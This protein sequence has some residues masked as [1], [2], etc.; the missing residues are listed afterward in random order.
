MTGSSHSVEITDLLAH[1]D[2]VGQLARRLVSSPA[3]AEDV[4][5]ETWVAAL[6]RPPA[7][8]DNPRG[9]LG[10]VARNV[11]RQ[12]ARGEKRRSRRELAVDRAGTSASVEELATRASLQRDVVGH[13]LALDE[14]LRATILLRF[15]EGLPPREVAERLGISPKT[16]SHRTHRALEM[17]RERLDGEFGAR[18]TWCAALAPLCALRGSAEVTAGSSVA[19]IGGWIV[20]TNAKMGLGVAVGLLGSLGLWRVLD[21]DR[22]GESDPQ[23][24]EPV[25]LAEGP[26][27]LPPPP[28]EDARRPVADPEEAEEEVPRV[29]LTE[30]EQATATSS[31]STVRGRVVDVRG[32]GLESVAIAGNA[33]DKVLARTVPDG[34]FEFEIEARAWDALRFRSDIYCLRVVDP[35]WITL[36]QSCVKETN[37]EEEHIVVAAPVRRL[38]G[39]VVDSALQPVAGAEVGLSAQSQSLYDF[40]YPLDTTRQVELEV[41]SDELGAFG[42]ERFPDA[43]GQRLYV[44]AEGFESQGFDLDELKEPYVLQLLA[45]EEKASPALEGIVLDEYGAA[46]EGALVKLAFSETRSGPDGRFGLPIEWVGPATPLCASLPGRLPALVPAFGRYLEDH[47]NRVPPVELVLG[48]EPLA[49][50]GRVLDADGEPCWDWTVQIAD[51]TEVS[52]GVVPMTSAE[53]LT[54]EGKGKVHT[55]RDG[56]FRIAGLLDRSYRV[57]AF[58][59]DTLFRVEQQ[60]EAGTQG[61]V[62]KAPAATRGDVRGR[63][64]APDGTPMAH[65][66]VQLALDT[67]VTSSGRSMAN[68]AKIVTDESGSFEFEDVPAEGVY[69]R[70]FGETI[71]PTE[72]RLPAAESLREYEVEVLRRCHFRIEPGELA[73]SAEFVE[74]LDAEGQRLQVNKFQANG[75]SAYPFA[76]LDEGRSEVMSVSEAAV[77]AVLRLGEQE[78][79]RRDIRLDP[80]NVIVLEL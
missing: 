44:R 16:V 8:G 6:E 56:R 64:V 25:V 47:Q 31:L 78:L 36:R 18:P 52:Q 42:F 11:A 67:V 48:G 10:Q 19:S 15:F 5:Q 26:S 37:T 33:D 45:E 77:T 13:V 14:P 66:R 34:S 50:E 4:V 55:G 35:Q 39:R 22:P 60:V 49:I 80:E 74:F 12:L 29:A 3:Q 72:F 65:I 32:R 2:W 61:V 73:R 28:V 24:A 68:G 27:A 38:E 53:E 21:S 69:L 54:R 20:K 7:H 71:L 63:V 40:P 70:L 23:I 76:F 62:L 46:V 30:P 79:G 43:S 9:W 1:A 59:S 58:D 75:M 17:L 51:E 57:L 41:T